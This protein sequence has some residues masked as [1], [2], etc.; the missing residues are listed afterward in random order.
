MALGLYRFDNAT[1]YKKLNCAKAKIPSIS[2]CV[3]DDMKL[4]CGSLIQIL[5]DVEQPSENLN[6]D[7]ITQ[8]YYNGKK[9]AFEIGNSTGG[10][11]DVRSGCHCSL[12]LFDPSWFLCH[13]SKCL[14]SHRFLE[15]PNPL[16]CPYIYVPVTNKFTVY[17][18]CTSI[19]K[20]WNTQLDK[21]RT[22]CCCIY[23][24]CLKNIETSCLC[25]KC[26]LDIECECTTCEGV[27]YYCGTKS[28]VEK[29]RNEIPCSH[30]R[31]EDIEINVSWMPEIFR[32]P[33][34][35]LG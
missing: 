20:G 4:P 17:R 3:Y 24:K 18:N 30:I 16:H 35:I 5:R 25:S 26:V 32:H 28:A 14:P 9:I 23:H 2:T 22:K 13:C 19:K 31:C 8:F 12:C 10:R 6:A 34:Y 29:T 11:I 27:C 15:E 21:M 33:K 1:L 7:G